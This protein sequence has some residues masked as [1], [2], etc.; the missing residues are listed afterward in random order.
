[1]ATKERDAPEGDGREPGDAGD[2][3]GRHHIVRLKR[4]RPPQQPANQRADESPHPPEAEHKPAPAEGEDKP[5]PAEPR[6]PSEPISRTERD[7]KG[8]L[9]PDQ[10]EIYRGSKPGSRYARLTRTRER[11]FERG[12]IAGTVRATAFADVPRTATGRAWRNIKRVLV[13][14]PLASRQLA[15]E[16]ISKTKALAIFASD[17]LSST[18][19][20]TEEILLVLVL[21]SAAALTYSIEISIAI[22]ALLLIVA[23]SYR[24]TIRA[25]PNGGGSYKVA[26]ENLGV[27]PGL[28]AGASL[29]VDYTLTVAVSTAAGVAAVTSAIPALYGDRVLLAVVFVSLL[30]LGN[31]RG[32]RESGTIFAIP[33]YFFLVTFGIMIIIGLVRAAFGDLHAAPHQDAIAFGGSSVTIFLI[34]RAFSSGATALTGIEAI[35]NGVPAFKEPS[36][37]NAA[38][39]LTWMAII[40]TTIFVGV[41][42][43]AHEAQ[44]YP[45]ESKTV[46]A[47]IADVVFNGG[48]MFYVIQVATALIL[49]LAANTSFAGLPALASVMAKDRYLPHIF[50]YRGDRLG[51]SNGI[52]ALAGA[53]IALLI[54]FGAQTHRLI[55]L[56]AVGVFIAFTLSQIG[57][58]VH[59]RHSDEPGKR[60]AMMINSVGGI[61]TGVVA[62]IIASTKFTHGAW[63]ALLTIVVLTLLFMATGRYYENVRKR[64]AI[65]SDELFIDIGA[66]RHGQFVLIPVDELNRATVRAVSYARSISNN[67]TAIHVTDNVEEAEALRR[68]WERHL[69]DVPLIVVE[70]EYRSLMGPVL[71]YVDALDRRDPDDVVTVVLPEYVARW[72]WERMLHNQSSGRLKKTLLERPNTVVIDVPYHV[73]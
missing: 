45:S 68:E 35:S 60:R 16:R 43:L 23:T 3:N 64:L 36:P 62:V 14:R 73:G 61:A 54:V 27:T 63:L 11:A 67:V 24:Q 2:E 41:T 13:G 53:S 39:T 21:A 1:M 12:D 69:V 17:A 34:L 7:G 65:G 37:K 32:L 72:P 55:P 29:V 15:E 48:P 28:I 47:Q 66:G 44:I 33:T 71:A 8:G 59:W 56:Y 70:S 50:Q 52:M 51:Y 58:V 25:Y 20:A 38:T 9:L 10:A 26:M 6:Q 18:A 30:T 31:L 22:A 49:I 57:M 19:Y 4:T 40:L 46:V 42:V 5:M